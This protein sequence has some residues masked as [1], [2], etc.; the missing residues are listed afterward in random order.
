MEALNVD[1]RAG[2]IAHLIGGH[3]ALQASNADGR[4]LQAISDAQ[5]CFKSAAEIHVGGFVDAFA[6]LRGAE[7]SLLAPEGLQKQTV[8]DAQ[9]AMPEALETL[10]A[11][12]APSLRAGLQLDAEIRAG[13][14][15]TAY[16]LLSPADADAQALDLSIATLA[17]ATRQPDGLARGGRRWARAMLT[18]AS[19][20]DALATQYAGAPVPELLDRFGGALDSSAA[21]LQEICDHARA[22]AP[23]IWANA[24]LLLAHRETELSGKATEDASTIAR[25]C[26]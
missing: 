10:A 7:A 13:I 19:A 1:D 6:K 2:A 15:L 16:L 3:V 24:H 17:F 26:C 23:E 20:W 4:R 25:P 9:D 12:D 8:V 18:L 14:G 21:T 11:A 5:Q 22:A